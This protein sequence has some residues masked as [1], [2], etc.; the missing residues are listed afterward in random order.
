MKTD[1][2]SLKRTLRS[3]LTAYGSIDDCI[4]IQKSWYSSPVENGQVEQEKSF[5][6]RQFYEG[7]F[8]LQ[9]KLKNR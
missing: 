7:F 2:F 8:F 1:F 3:C 5:S 6:P 4:G 9:V